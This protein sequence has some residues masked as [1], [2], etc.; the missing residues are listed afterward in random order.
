MLPWLGPAPVTIIPGLM[1][2]LVMQLFITDLAFHLGIKINS[3]N[4]NTAHRQPVV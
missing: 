3:L 2:G 4:E 1:N